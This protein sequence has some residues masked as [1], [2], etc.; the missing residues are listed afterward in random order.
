VKPRFHLKDGVE[1]E[2]LVSPY[3]FP[4]FFLLVFF[5]LLDEEPGGF[6]ADFSWVSPSKR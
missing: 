1:G 2:T 6:N 3:F 5:F 4:F